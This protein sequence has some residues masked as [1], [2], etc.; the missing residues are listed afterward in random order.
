M[1]Q[2]TV[3]LNIDPRQKQNLESISCY[4]KICL[5]KHK[6]LVGLTAAIAIRKTMAVYSAFDEQVIKNDFN[7]L[8]TNLSG[9]ATRSPRLQ[10]VINNPSKLRAHRRNL[11]LRTVGKIHAQPIYSPISC[12]PNLVNLDLNLLSEITPFEA[13]DFF[14]SSLHIKDTMH[15]YMGSKINW[16]DGVAIPVSKG[17]NLTY[18]EHEIFS[19]K[20]SR[21]KAFSIP[22]KPSAAKDSPWKQAVINQI[23]QLNQLS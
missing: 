23:D 12:H 21:I 2:I 8:L 22:Q 20:M 4:R 19:D 6:K 1:S 3:N 10:A 14:S 5:S 16:N 9:P 13:E 7:D 15:N 18:L 11:M 17:A